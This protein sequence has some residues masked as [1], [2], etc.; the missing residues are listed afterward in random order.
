M[1]GMM[2]EP[3]AAADSLFPRA[4]RGQGRGASAQALSEPDLHS[5]RP[6]PVRRGIPVHLLVSPVGRVLQPCVGSEAAEV[7]TGKN[8]E[9]QVRRK[10]FVTSGHWIRVEPSS[11]KHGARRERQATTRPKGSGQKR[12]V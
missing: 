6:P 1:R 8:V 10:L 7:V 11:D 5:R 9:A 2:R 4:G 12:A 3:N